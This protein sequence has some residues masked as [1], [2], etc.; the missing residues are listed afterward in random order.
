MSSNLLPVDNS[1]LSSTLGCEAGRLESQTGLE[2]VEEVPEGKNL[3]SKG[4]HLPAF[5]FF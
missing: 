3:S 2:R 4:Y 1:H 5:R